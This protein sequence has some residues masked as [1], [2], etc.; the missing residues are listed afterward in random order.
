[1]LWDA[2]TGQAGALGVVIEHWD[3]MPEHLERQ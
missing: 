3:V 1:M 2:R